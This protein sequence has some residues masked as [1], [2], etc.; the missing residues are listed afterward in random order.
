MMKF[1][2][3]GDVSSLLTDNKILSTFATGHVSSLPLGLLLSVQMENRH[4]RKS[5]IFLSP[6]TKA[7][8]PPARPP[9]PPHS[10][11]LPP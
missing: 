10:P 6:P 2:A 5:A 3:G 1:R 9:A 8:S 4:A 7:E 11:S